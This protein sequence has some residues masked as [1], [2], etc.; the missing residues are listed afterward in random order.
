[1]ESGTSGE[2]GIKKNIIK[3][4]EVE[5]GGGCGGRKIYSRGFI[6]AMV[7]MTIQFIYLLQISHILT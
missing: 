5:R 4:H 1:M 7:F 2:Q 3:N 6:V